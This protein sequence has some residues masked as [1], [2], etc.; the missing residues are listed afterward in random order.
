MGLR[1]KFRL[2]VGVAAGGLLV[3]SVFWVTSERSRIL[4]AK[5]DQTRSLVEAAYNI[6]AREHSMEVEG[7]VSREEGQKRAVATTL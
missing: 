1:A 2:I 7:A 3:L 4:S 5:E 6:A